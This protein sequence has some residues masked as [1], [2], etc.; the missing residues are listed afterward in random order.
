MSFLKIKAGGIPEVINAPSSKSY[1]NRALICG[2]LKKEKVIIENINLCD[3][4]VY[5]IKALEKIGLKITQEK[6][7]IEIH[8]YF[9]LCE[10]QGCELEVGSGGTTLRFLLPLL[11]L[12]RQKYKV[13]LSEDLSMRPHGAL[14]NALKELGVKVKEEKMRTLFKG[15]F[16][17]K[18]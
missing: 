14:I 3:D 6:N 12:G 5:L 8:N 4:V 2:A 7:K 10:G 16:K 1:L 15:C 18:K 9:P 17:E 13:I 11:A